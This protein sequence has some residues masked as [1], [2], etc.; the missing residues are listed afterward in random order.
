LR[1]LSWNEGE[2][3]KILPLSRDCLG[4]IF[5]RIPEYNLNRKLLCSK[6]LSIDKKIE[7]SKIF[8]WTFSQKKS[9]KILKKYFLKNIQIFSFLW[10][11]L[12]RLRSDK[13]VDWVD[14]NSDQWI[15]FFKILQNLT[16]YTF[17]KAL[18]VSRKDCHWKREDIFL[19]I[20]IIMD[21]SYNIKILDSQR[22]KVKID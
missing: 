17:W 15:F 10:Y 7:K 11:L 2:Q 4:L 12:K 19:I 18:V 16:K 5:S 3:N 13:S 8:V 9:Q 22:Y 20:L 1:L 6:N 21:D 14:Q